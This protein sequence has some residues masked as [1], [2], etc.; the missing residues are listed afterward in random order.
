MKSP[1]RRR[2]VRRE[3][4][5]AGWQHNTRANGPQEYPEQALACPMGTHTG[6]SSLGSGSRL[7]SAERSQEDPHDDHPKEQ[8]QS[9]DE[10]KGG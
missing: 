10:R 5:T 9:D 8:G 3:P 2:I 4:N 6:S 1:N 7:L